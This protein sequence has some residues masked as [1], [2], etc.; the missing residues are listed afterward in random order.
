MARKAEMADAA[1]RLL[2]EEVLHK[3]V[4]AV[5][6]VAFD[7]IFVDIV[8]QIKVE[9]L[10]AAPPEL[11]FKDL[12]GLQG[13]DALH[14]LVA[15]ELVGQVPLLARIAAQRAAERRFRAPAVI[16]IGR[17]EIVD[18]RGD[19]RVDHAVEL[20]LVD[21][22]VRACRQAH[23]PEAQGREL[24]LLKRMVQHLYLLPCIFSLHLLR[25]V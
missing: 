7:R 15:G 10:H 5:S 9:I 19:G 2:L 21:Q 13:L 4:G 24:F 17:V 20:L 11:L 23:G 22:P 8:Q 25:T 18:A 14:I 12:G 6:I 3:A 16:G 1:P